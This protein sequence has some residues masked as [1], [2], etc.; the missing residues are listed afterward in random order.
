MDELSN[1]I[2]NSAKTA[3]IDSSIMSDEHYLPKLVYNNPKHGLIVLSEIE[4]ELENCD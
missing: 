1:K 4:K 2:I 3:L